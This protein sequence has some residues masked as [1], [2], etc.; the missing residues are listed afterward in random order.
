MENC[1]VPFKD[2]FF[3]STEHKEEQMSDLVTMGK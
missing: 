3:L 2:A 1:H